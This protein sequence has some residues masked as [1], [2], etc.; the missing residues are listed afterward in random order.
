M[1]VVGNGHVEVE[2]AATLTVLPE[3]PGSRLAS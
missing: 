1:L 2:A 3:G